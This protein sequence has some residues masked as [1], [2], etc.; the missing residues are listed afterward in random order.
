MVCIEATYPLQLVHLDFLQIGS[1]TKDKGKPIYVMVVTDHFTRYAKAYVTTNQMAQLVAHVF[2]N[3]YV[4]NYGWPEKI[5][6]NQAKGFEGKVF[7]E[8][9][10]QALI[11][12]LHMTPYHPQGNGQ[13]ER[14]NRT[15]LTML[16]TL[17]LDSKKRWEDWVSNLTQAYNSSP[18]RVTGFST[19]YL[20]FGREPHILVDQIFNVTYPETGPPVTKKYNDYVFKLKERLEWAYKTTQKH[21]ERDATRRKQY[22]DRKFH[23][24]EIIPGD[25]VL[26]HQKVFGTTR[27]IKDWWENPVYQVIEKMGDGPVYKIQKLG[28]NGE[29][30]IRELHRNMLHPLM[31]VV[32]EP[33]EAQV[34]GSESNDND[35]PLNTT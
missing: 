35:S 8:L 15:L 21:I 9:C 13:P 1:K 11:K 27:K 28:E 3:E 20:M 34:M 16:G 26:V 23:C 17:P 19:Y 32:E 10:D 33:G 25:M 5:L 30:A 29:K 7:K 22:Y 6:T 24:M 2:I 18:S 4:A 12:K 31:Q 14:F